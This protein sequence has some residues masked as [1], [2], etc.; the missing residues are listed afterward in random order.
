LLTDRDIVVR[1]VAKGI[2][3][4]RAVRDVMT[5]DISFCYE[6]EDVTLVARNMA[7]AKVQRFPVFDRDHTLVGI[8]SL[9]DIARIYEWSRTEEPAT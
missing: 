9:T 7:K 8:I 6:D 4:S 1:V 3:T 2:D 5:P